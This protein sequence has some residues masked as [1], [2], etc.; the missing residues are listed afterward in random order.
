M[1]P[2]GPRG[3]VR[4]SSPA[5]AFPVNRFVNQCRAELL[6]V[7]RSPHIST[8]LS[9]SRKPTLLQCA[10]QNFQTLLFSSFHKQNVLTVYL[11]VKFVLIGR[12]LEYFQATMSAKNTIRV[13]SKDC[14][15]A[16]TRSV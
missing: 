2:L 1:N 12:E 5:E 11:T 13:G 6:A 14:A 16:R 10:P 9:P 3:I 15:A 8:S 7:K 4:C